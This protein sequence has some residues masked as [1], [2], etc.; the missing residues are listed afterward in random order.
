MKRFYKPD[1]GDKWRENFSVDIINGTP[2]NELKCHNR[3]LISNF[4]R[5]GY[6]ADGSWRVFGLRKDFYPAAKVQMED[7]ITASVV[8]P[9]ERLQNLNPD[10][11]NPSVKFVHNC[12]ARLFQRP[13]EAIHRGYDK[14]TEQDL[15]EPGNFLSNFEPLRQADARAWSRMPSVL[16][17][18]PSRCGG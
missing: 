13:D 12:E 1:W 11:S 5:V 4:L 3:K 6:D 8:V 7:D 17:N 9:A 2:G 14:Q 15:S 16:S 10:Y 18:I